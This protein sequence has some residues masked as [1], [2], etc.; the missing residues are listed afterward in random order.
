MSIILIQQMKVKTGMKINLTMC[1]YLFC[2]FSVKRR[3]K[4][5]Q[6]VDY[7]NTEVISWCKSFILVRLVCNWRLVRKH[8][9]GSWRESEN[10]KLTFKSSAVLDCAYLEAN[11]VHV[12]CKHTLIPTRALL[13]RRKLLLLANSYWALPGSWK[14]VGKCFVLTLAAW[15]MQEWH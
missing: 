14:H 6:E 3:Y 15:I 7:I 12:A 8:C 13:W 11:K 1:F 4:D 10:G 2:A 5:E 9:T